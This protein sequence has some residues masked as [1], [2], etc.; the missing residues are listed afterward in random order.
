M[1]AEILSREAELE[2]KIEERTRELTTLL[3][4]SRDV[5]SNLSLDIV[6]HEILDK[7]KTVVRYSNATICRLE[8]DTFYS[9]ADWEGMRENL[10]LD[11]RFSAL[12]FIDQ[13]VMMTRK[14]L[15]IGDVHK[16]DTDVAIDFRA[17]ASR[18]LYTYYK[19][20]RN[21]MRVPLIFKS[22]ITGLLTLHYHEPNY[23][24]SRHA[25]LAMAFAEHAAIAIENA[26][27]FEKARDLA[28]MEERQKLA[29]ELHDSVSQALYGIVLGT[30][31]ARKL[32]SRDPDRIGEPLDYISSLAE[33]GLAEMR[34]LIF[35]LRPESLQLEGLIAALTKQCD[36]VRSRHQLVV[37]SIFPPEPD[38]PIEIKEVFYRVAQEALHNIVKH[39]RAT[40]VELRLE[41]RQN[42]VFLSIHD[43]GTGFETNRDYPGHLGLISMRERVENAGGC[44][45][46]ESTPGKGTSIEASITLVQ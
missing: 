28:A 21:W 40:V 41:T 13:R 9:I 18:N 46:L 36:A 7:L 37:N 27:L 4:V 33:A 3:Q 14:P 5:T 45:K 10:G 26:R 2:R 8:G 38:I 23:Y 17:Q 12:N 1:K 44:F 43:D 16:D 20:V 35:A 39:A 25:D 6:L 34:A 29:R 11:I 30:R 19:S 32:L 24:T 42:R 15:I 22:S 31:T